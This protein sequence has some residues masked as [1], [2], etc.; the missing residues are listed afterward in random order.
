VT[1]PPQAASPL[2]AH[3]GRE[4]PGASTRARVAGLVRT[5]GL[6]TTLARLGLGVV[7][8]HVLDDSFFQPQPGTSAGDHLVSG[9]VPTAALLALAALYPRLRPG[10]RASLA[11][12]AGLFGVVVGIEAVYYLDAGQLSGDDYTGLAA[13]PA[14]LLLLGIAATTLWRSR[15]VSDRLW[16][17]YLRRSLLAVA[18]VV[19]G[20]AF[21]APFL[22]SYVLTHSARSFVPTYTVG[23]THEDVSFTTDDGLRLRGWYVPSKNG[24][25]V[26]SFPGRKGTQKPA[27]ILAQH[28]YGVLL[29]DRRG[30]GQSEGDPNAWGWNGYR[31]V[32][33]AVRYLESRPDV[34]GGQIGGIGLS[35]GGEMM[36]EA[37]ARSHGMK[38]VVSE[39]A[40]ERSVHEVVDMTGSGKWLSLASYGPLSAGIAL[41]SNDAPPP[42]LKDL[43]GRIAP[44]PVFFVYGEHGQDGERNLNP[45]YYEAA[46]KPKAIWEVPDSGHVGGIDAHP[47]EYERRVVGFFD[48]A[49][50]QG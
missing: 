8:L 7:A 48:R 20:Y 41:F 1:S 27:R 9:L 12:L 3:Q 47:K 21:V 49:L 38:A 19:A 30:E 50:L 16:W 43:V 23:A 11:A 44:T 36:L 28:G 29:F 32:D 14:G 10:L 2:P 6:E 5:A 18:V 26:I 42:S 46:G 40:G 13:I 25:A 4:G 34:H 24:A 17:R 31:D 35:V 37:A 39:G 33:A 22:A 45:T 15:R